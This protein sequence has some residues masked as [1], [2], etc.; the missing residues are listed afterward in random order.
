MAGCG[1]AAGPKGSVLAPRPAAVL[2]PHPE[3]VRLDAG[4]LRA[5]VTRGGASVEAFVVLHAA[6]AAAA[7]PRAFIH[8]IHV[9]V[10]SVAD[11]RLPVLLLIWESG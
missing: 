2:P 6:G 3:A 4:G 9:Q 11:V 5:A 1:G 8:L 7:G 10:Q